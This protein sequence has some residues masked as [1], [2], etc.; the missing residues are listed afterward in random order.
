MAFSLSS[1]FLIALWFGFPRK[2]LLQQ[3]RIRQAND[4]F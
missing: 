2:V 3:M 4:Q 1:V